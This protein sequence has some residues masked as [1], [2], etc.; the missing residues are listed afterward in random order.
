MRY[1]GRTATLDGKGLWSLWAYIL[2]TQQTV[3][4]NR[5]GKIGPSVVVG[6]SGHALKG[7][8]RAWRWGGPL[9]TVGAEIAPSAFSATPQSVVIYG[10]SIVAAAM[11][12]RIGR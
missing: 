3:A 10:S 6:Y 2:F 7:G 4:A 11:V 5:V 8:W 1:R 12:G 9:V